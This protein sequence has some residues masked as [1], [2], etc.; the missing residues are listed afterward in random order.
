MVKKLIILTLTLLLI[1]VPLAFSIEFDDNDDNVF[2][3]QFKFDSDNI[4]V[5]TFYDDF[6]TI[7]TNQSNCETI[8]GLPYKLCLDSETNILYYWDGDSVESVGAGSVSTHESTYPHDDYDTHIAAT[9]NTHSADLEDIADGVSVGAVT[10]TGGSFDL[11]AVTVSLA[12]SPTDTLEA[13]ELNDTSDPHT[14]TASELYGTFLSNA[15]SSGADEWDF[16]ARSE[17]WDFCFDKEV[18]QNITLDPN[19]TEQWY[20]RTDN[21]SYTQLSAGEALVNTTAGKSTICCHSTEVAVYC[22][23]DE[24]WAEETP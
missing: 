1:N 5:G 15:E 7:F 8:D 6:M 11:T 22:N 4:T 2:D 18:N 14:L 13:S 16:P 10:P 21:S 19:G 12:T 23:A 17:G 20:Y 24:N 9:G 3:D